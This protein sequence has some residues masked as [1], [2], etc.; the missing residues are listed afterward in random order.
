MEIDKIIIEIFEEPDKKYLQ[1]DIHQY[2]NIY[3]DS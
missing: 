3:R 2:F 1:T